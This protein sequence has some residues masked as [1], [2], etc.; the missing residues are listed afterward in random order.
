MT[1]TGSVR[2]DI[3]FIDPVIGVGE[4]AISDHRSSQPTL[5]EVLRVASEAYVGGMLANKAGVVHF[6]VGNG[7]RGLS[8]LREAIKTS[9]IPP[10]VFYP[11]H[12][13]RR[14]GLLEEAIDL[15]TRGSFVDVT[16][17]SDSAAA[18]DGRTADDAVEAAEAIL[19][20]LESGGPADRLTASSDAGGSLPTFDA[21]GHMTHM[22]VGE[23]SA[24]TA[25]LTR[26]LRDDHSPRRIVPVFTLNP[27]RALRLYKKGQIARG[28]DADLVV[29]GDRFEVQSVM[30]RGRW[31]HGLHA[32]A[33]G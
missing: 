31:V 5:D 4:I 29:L 9:E 7:P 15:A 26:L 6:H 27:A 12:V 19:H 11:T 10:R 30:A 1:L 24:L 8:L 14:A 23:P 17:Y 13:N 33:N 20:Y 25:C 18:P 32:T 21:E 3:V 2:K 28:S 16:A 22:G